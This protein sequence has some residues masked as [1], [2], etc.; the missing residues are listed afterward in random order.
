MRACMRDAGGGGRG[1]GGVHWMNRQMRR[2]EKI[3]IAKAV[4]ATI[5]SLDDAPKGYQN[6]DKGAAVKYV[7][8]PHGV[9]GKTVKL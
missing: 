8:D 5:I 7:I 6:F 9:T 1:E 3:H 4:G 2:Y